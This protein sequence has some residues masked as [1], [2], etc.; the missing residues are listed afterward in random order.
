MLSSANPASSERKA[1][2]LCGGKRSSAS[3]QKI[4]SPRAHRIDSLRAAEKSSHHGKS[5]TRAPAAR[6]ISRVASVEPVST[7]TTSSKSADAEARHAPMFTASLRATIQSETR[8]ISSSSLPGG[9]RSKAPSPTSTAWDAT[10]TS[11]PTPIADTYQ[12]PPPPS[13]TFIRRAGSRIHRHDC[14]RSSHD[15]QAMYDEQPNSGG[16]QSASTDPA[17][18]ARERR[19]KD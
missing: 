1:G 19:R 5:N 16:A 18:P 4:H 17:N 6:A 13:R 12:H 8:A 9:R 15:S 2:T 10:Q 11:P 14:Y 3:I 7:T